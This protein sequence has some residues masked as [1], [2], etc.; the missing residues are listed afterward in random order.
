MSSLFW[1]S[2]KKLAQMAGKW[3]QPFLSSWSPNTD[4]PYQESIWDTDKCLTLINS[5]SVWTCCFSNNSM[6]CVSFL[7]KWFFIK[8]FR[9]TVFWL[10]FYF[11]SFSLITSFTSP[12]KVFLAAV[13]SC[14]IHYEEN[15]AATE[16]GH[17]PVTLSYNWMQIL[18]LKPRE[19]VKGLEGTFVFGGETVHVF[20]FFFFS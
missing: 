17:Q 5:T 1:K 11:K 14:P 18:P 13:K 4:V 12:W 10:T 16:L 8:Y 7:D 19:T 3:S 20:F 9:Q 15:K 6:D 2:L